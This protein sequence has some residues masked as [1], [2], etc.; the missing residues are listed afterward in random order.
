M[1]EQVLAWA[2]WWEVTTLSRILESVWR[3]TMTQKEEGES[4]EGLPGLLRTIPSA[5]LREGGWKRWASRAS[6][7]EGRREG[8]WRCL[9]FQTEYGMWSGPGA[10]VFEDFER[11]LDIA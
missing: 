7:R 8:L 4:E 10:E 1:R 5:F 2:E 9:Y 11:A 3:R 6:R